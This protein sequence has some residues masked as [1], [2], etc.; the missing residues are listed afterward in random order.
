MK[1][2]ILHKATDMF[3]SLG[4]KSFTM[5]DIAAELGVSKKTIYNHFSNKTALVN[6]VTNSV[7]EIVCEGIDLICSK[8]ENPIDELYEIKRFSMDYLK[9]EKTI[10]V[11]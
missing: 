10:K 5:D 3:L 7:F 8:E 4:F 11:S 9:N 6:E 2:K 1:Q